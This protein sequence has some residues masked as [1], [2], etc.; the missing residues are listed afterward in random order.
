[1]QALFQGYH[2]DSRVHYCIIT[3]FHISRAQISPKADQPS[4]D[5][6]K[7]IVSHDN[8]VSGRNIATAPYIDHPAIAGVKWLTNVTYNTVFNINPRP[9]GI[10]P[11]HCLAG[12]VYPAICQPHG[13]VTYIYP[14]STQQETS[15]IID[16]GDIG[17]VEAKISL[18]GERA[19]C[20]TTPGRSGLNNG[21][22]AGAIL[23]PYSKVITGI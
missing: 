23:N 10:E 19:L 1:M 13:Y 21:H 2:L 11:D 5:V 6:I 20:F 17:A 14:E 3:D 4:R 18:D 7:S 8:G 15:Y 12:T 16:I 22:G 9:R